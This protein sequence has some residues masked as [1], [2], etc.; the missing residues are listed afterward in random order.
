[1]FKSIE[2]QFL[3]KVTD[4]ALGTVFDEE[5]LWASLGRLESLKYDLIYSRSH[6]GASHI[7]AYKLK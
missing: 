2:H 6:P 3:K 5:C 4:K 7:F 1:M